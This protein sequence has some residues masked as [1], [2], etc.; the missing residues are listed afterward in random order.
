MA[1]PLDSNEIIKQSNTRTF[2]QPGGVG[3]K[4]LFFGIDTQYH[5]IDSASI[6][7][8]GSIDPV[9]VPD[10]RRPGRYRLVARSIGAPDLPTIG[11]TFNESWGG[12]P[13]VLMAPQ[14]EFNM[15]EVHGRCSDL[16]DLYRGWDSYAMIYSGFKFSGTADLGTRT[17]AD[18]DE[19]LKESI[20]ATGIAAYP[21]GAL[22]FGEE[23]AS[24][25]VVS[26]IGAV[27]GTDVQCADCGT[28][29]DGSQ[30]I[31]AVTR[32]NVGSPSAPGQVIYTLDGGTTW[33]TAL[34]TGIGVSAEVTHIDIAGSILFVT[35][36]TTAMYYS[37][38]NSE[39]G[40][41][42]T[43]S[44]VTQ[45]A[46]ITDVYVQSPN[47]IY[48]VGGT[49]SIYKTDNITVAATAMSTMD[50]VPEL[51]NETVVHVLPLSVVL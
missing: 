31:Y 29:N 30:F 12:I 3:T 44:S 49:G 1:N 28:A 13:R 36:N 45:P 22:S 6:P 11:L 42:T 10:P 17:A 23:A 20:D 5:Y 48:F 47:A 7:T 50:P 26:V 24:D 2:Y 16:S 51:G 32:A 41:P 46:A 14:C 21:V 15:I 18:S 19:I 8:N 27:Y 4:P 38:L 33:T 40:A 9:F 39:T 37:V 34:I 43:W 25:V 35:T